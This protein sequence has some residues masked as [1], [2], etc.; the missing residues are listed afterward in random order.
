MYGW[1]ANGVP[2]VIPDVECAI[3]MWGG[4]DD[5]DTGPGAECTMVEVEVEGAVDCLDRADG[6]SE[7]TQ[8]EERRDNVA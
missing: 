4:R 7:E 3:W 2:R 8:L 1:E 6:R 5:W